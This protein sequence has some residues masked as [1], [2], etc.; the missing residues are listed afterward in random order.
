M[1][2]LLQEY[3][4]LNEV[5]QHGSGEEAVWPIELA[6]I[7]VG[8]VRIFVLLRWIASIKVPTSQVLDGLRGCVIE[9]LLGRESL[10]M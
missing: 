7:S 8:H 5:R 6:W 2:R 10:V 1:S 4:T 3:T 9:G